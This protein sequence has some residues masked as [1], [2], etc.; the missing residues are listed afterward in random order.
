M[1]TGSYMTPI[2]SRSQSEVLGDLH[3]CSC[4]SIASQTCLIGERSGYLTG[5][6]SVIQSV[7]YFIAT[8]AVCGQTLSCR[9]KNQCTAKGT[10]EKQFSQCRQRTVTL[11]CKCASNDCQMGPA[12]KRND[13][14]YHNSLLR[15]CVACNSESRIGTLP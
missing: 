14:P 13:T 3:R 6:G 15:D 10:V 2:Y 5:Q 12:V 8:R 7:R 4:L 1:A 11:C 9:K